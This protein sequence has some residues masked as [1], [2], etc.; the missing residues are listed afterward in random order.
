L[1][2]SEIAIYDFSNTITLPSG[3]RM[4]LKTT[5]KFSIRHV[6]TVSALYGIYLTL[7]ILLLLVV[8]S[9]PSSSFSS[10]P[11]PRPSSSLSGWDLLLLV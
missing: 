1:R 8:S 10:P 9:S 6:T 5:G 7:F 2:S 11:P 3:E 4:K